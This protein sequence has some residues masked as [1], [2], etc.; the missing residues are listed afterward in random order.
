MDSITGSIAEHREAVAGLD[1]NGTELHSNIVLDSTVQEA[2]NVASASIQNAVIA[3]AHD[4]NAVGVGNQ[5]LVD[6]EENLGTF[7]NAIDNAF[8]PG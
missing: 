7:V 3:V 6:N 4:A 5:E 2:S 8:S 1:F